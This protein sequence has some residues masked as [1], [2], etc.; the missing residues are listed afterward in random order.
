[1]VQGLRDRR[2]WA[3]KNLPPPSVTCGMEM[4]QL[5]WKASLA[6]DSG[7]PRTARCASVL[8]LRANAGA[9]LAKARVARAAGYEAVKLK[10]GRQALEDDIRLVREVRRVLGSGIALRLDANR[11]WSYG[12]KRGPLQKAVKGSRHSICGRTAAEPWPAAGDSPL[13]ACRT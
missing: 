12:S 11:A 13:H 1:M 4:A 10:V 6:G 9:V 2:F 7:L 3:L 8:C 5:Q